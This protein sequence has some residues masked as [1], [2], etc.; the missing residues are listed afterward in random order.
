M[1]KSML[2]TI[3]ILFMVLLSP[4]QI[5]CAEGLSLKSADN[6]VLKNPGSFNIT[7]IHPPYP[8]YRD[9]LKPV[10]D[11]EINPFLAKV[12]EFSIR[13]YSGKADDIGQK[14]YEEPGRYYLEVSRGDNSVFYE[15][16][17]VWRIRDIMQ[18]GFSGGNLPIQLKVKVSEPP[19][20]G[21]PPGGYPYTEY[22]IGLWFDDDT[23][24][25]FESLKILAN[26]LPQIPVIISKVVTHWENNR[27]LGRAIVY[28]QYEAPSFLVVELFKPMGPFPDYV[29]ASKRI[30]IYSN[31]LTGG[32]YKKLTGEASYGGGVSNNVEWYGLTLRY[33]INIAGKRFSCALNG[34]DEDNFDTHCSLDVR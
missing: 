25:S 19:I 22:E 7:T 29:K 31:E 34:L 28:E 13:L 6:S 11:I 17:N 21:Q 26:K 32:E 27:M 8:P 12:H 5:V 33:T 3:S 16:E 20:D 30:D 9:I 10:K 24:Y 23:T 14:N 2:F 1:K 15:F 4:I 18:T